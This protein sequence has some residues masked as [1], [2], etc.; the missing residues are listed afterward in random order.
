MSEKVSEG[1][2]RPHRFNAECKQ[3]GR[4]KHAA[5]LYSFHRRCVRMSA[6]FLAYQSA[7]NGQ[8]N[9]HRLPQHS[10][11]LTSY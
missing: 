6:R 1:D 9:G 2:I 11:R 4:A 8:A 3:L 5:W 10:N 7:N